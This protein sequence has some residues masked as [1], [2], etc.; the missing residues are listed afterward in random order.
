MASTNG[1]N[2][3][4]KKGKRSVTAAARR[5]NSMTSIASRNNGSDTPF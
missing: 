3:K 1:S 2:G 4:K 5:S